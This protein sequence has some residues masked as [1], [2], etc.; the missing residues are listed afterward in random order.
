MKVEIHMLVAVSL[1]TA[2]CAAQG[3][4]WKRLGPR[5]I[6]DDEHGRGEVRLDKHI[7]AHT[8]RARTP[9]LPYICPYSCPYMYTTQAGTLATAASPAE[10]PSL[11]YTGG[12]N[13]GA[14][15]GVM[16]TT[17]M[18]VTWVQASTG[19]FDT[20]VQGLF[21]YPSPTTT[22]TTASAG[23]HVLCGGPSGIYESLDG[24]ASWTH[25][26]ASS[27][28]G[29]VHTFRLG[30]INGDK[31]VLAATSK[32]IANIPIKGGTWNLIPSPHGD[33][34]T[35]LSIAD[36]GPNTVAC[37]CFG[38]VVLATITSPTTA[39]FTDRP[40]LQCARCSTAS[41]LLFRCSVDWLHL[42]D[43]TFWDRNSGH[44]RMPELSWY[45]K[46]IIGV[47]HVRL[48]LG[49][50]GYPTSARTKNTHMPRT[51]PPL[52]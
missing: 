12:S 2:A 31:Y 30:T 50:E 19:L 46:S 15:S 44:S 20:R 9:Q 47:S 48:V 13:N 49:V 35:P 5:N 42:I 8:L 21:V 34:R 4:A 23:Q 29:Q 14:S 39:T 10:N 25:I 33:W 17:D 24:A 36:D 22:T 32:G 16:K 3:S 40:E 45:P 52:H 37:G 27:A 11:I 51:N 7:P 28:F 26:I 43:G 18:G 1:A 41:L 38:F 6:F